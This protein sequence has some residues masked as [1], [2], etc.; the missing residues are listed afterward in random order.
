MNNKL[1]LEASIDKDGGKVCFD[2]LKLRQFLLGIRGIIDRFKSQ[3]KV[4]NA[5]GGAF[6]VF[7]LCKVDHY[8]TLHSRILAE[9]LSPKGSHGQKGVFLRKF[10]E[11]FLPGDNNCFSARTDVRCE[12]SVSHENRTGDR[13]DILL[14]DS[15]TRSV[16]IVENKI[17]AGEQPKQLSRYAAW[18]ENR[19]KGGWKT[20]LVFLTPDGH[21]ASTISDPKAYVRVA[22]ANTGGQVDVLSWL[23][24]CKK[25]AVDIPFVRETLAQYYNHIYNLTKGERKMESELKEWIKAGDMEAAQAVYDNYE[26]ACYDCATKLIDAAT[27]AFEVK[28]N[29]SKMGRV[30]GEIERG[31]NYA[32]EDS[33]AAIEVEGKDGV[34]FKIQLGFDGKKFKSFRVA[35]N[36]DWL[37][38]ECGNETAEETWK[39]LC[40][41]LNE[42]DDAVNRQWGHNQSWPLWRYVSVVPSK[43]SGHEQVDTE[44]WDGRFFEWLKRDQDSEKQLIEM[45]ADDM[46]V[47]VKAVQDFYLRRKSR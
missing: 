14:E 27:A 34:K 33:G 10:V 18:L 11:M 9:F 40:E 19:R 15:A 46:V 7:E 45:I 43:T 35:L 6:N 32:G 1:I 44:T 39:E 8:E 37:P 24:E 28:L 5:Y 2:E 13:F 31:L 41:E 23:L 16:C 3:R 20:F 17:N 4:L 42:E 26:S 30:M 38:E 36:V 21:A 22:Y 12:V 25:L 29:Q 47:M